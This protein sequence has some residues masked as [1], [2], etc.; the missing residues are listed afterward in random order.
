MS[1]TAYLPI[2]VQVALAGSITIGVIAA[3]TFLGQ[4]FKKN[5]TG[6]RQG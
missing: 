5:A 4:R 1:Y 2:F 3:S 6:H